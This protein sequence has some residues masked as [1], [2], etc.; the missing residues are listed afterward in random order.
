MS[1][2]IQKQFIPGNDSIWVQQLNE[3]DSI[4]SFETTEEAESQL[5]ALQS[6]DTEG[7]SY[8]IVEA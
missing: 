7:R 4:Y 2:I 6:A 5:T 8:Q 1:Y 3:S